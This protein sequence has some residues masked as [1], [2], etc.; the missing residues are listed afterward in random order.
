M[1]KLAIEKRLEKSLNR[2]KSRQRDISVGKK[3]GLKHTY[4]MKALQYYLG[5]KNKPALGK[6]YCE[7]F[8]QSIAAI[9]FTQKLRPIS[10]EAI[11]KSQVNCPIFDEKHRG[12]RQTSRRE[13]N[14]PL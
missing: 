3:S 5:I 6:A 7:H 12:S 10:D 4:Y 1:S 11:Y 8:L 9:K 2:S 14:H 13:E